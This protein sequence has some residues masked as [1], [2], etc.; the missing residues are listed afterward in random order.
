MFFNYSIHHTTEV[1][2][3]MRKLD[4]SRRNVLRTLGAT[5]L[6][7]GAVPTVAAQRGGLKRELAEVRSATAEYNDPEKAYDDGYVVPGEDGPIPLEDVTEEAHAVCGMGYHFVNMDLFGTAD[8]TEPQVLAY[9]VDD[10]N[11]ILGAV[12]YVV[13]KKGAYA[14][15]PPD[16]FGHD[17]GDEKWEED[18]PFP[19]VWSL[20]AWVHNRNPDGVFAPLN[21]RKQ[22]QVGCED[23][24]EH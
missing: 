11:L 18:S 13:P 1:E 7:S 6:A 2:W 3:G 15:S 16:L 19:G 21:P 12:E 24:H 9:G 5:A 14:D 20:H 17:D 8:R 23:D 4:I 10:D 22:F